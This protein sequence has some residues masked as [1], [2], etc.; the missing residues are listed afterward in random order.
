MVEETLERNRL[1]EAQTPQGFRRDVILEAY[2]R[3]GAGDATDDASLVERT[4][5][6]VAVVEGAYDNIKVTTPEDIVIAEA[7]LRRGRRRI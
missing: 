3:F 5:V 7:L 4:G 2:A 1:W 6:T